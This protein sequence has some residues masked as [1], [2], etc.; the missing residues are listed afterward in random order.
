MSTSSSSSTAAS[1]SSSWL[2]CKGQ[3]KW[4]LSCA[5]GGPRSIWQMPGRP[6]YTCMRYNCCVFRF[7]DGLLA[8]GE[9]S[10]FH[11]AT[12]SGQL[13]LKHWCIH[14]AMITQL[15]IPSSFRSISGTSPSS[16]SSLMLLAVLSWTARWHAKILDHVNGAAH[17]WQQHRPY[18][19]AQSYGLPTEGTTGDSRTSRTNDFQCGLCCRSWVCRSWV[20]P[21]TLR[22]LVRVK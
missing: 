21:S 11:S 22:S 14:T 12:C 13:G 7:F 2:G 6:N 20:P 15:A 9:P 8:S 19:S 17:Y 18:F 4:I 5:W 10:S 3:D 1:S 16:Q